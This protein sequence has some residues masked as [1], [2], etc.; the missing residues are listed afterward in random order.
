MLGNCPYRLCMCVICVN[1]V[2]GVFSCFVDVCQCDIVRGGEIVYVTGCIFERCLGV[3]VPQLVE[4]Y[5][6]LGDGE[7]EWGVVSGC[8]DWW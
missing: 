5:E 2:N 1:H 3:G 7:D 4:V 8:W 6:G